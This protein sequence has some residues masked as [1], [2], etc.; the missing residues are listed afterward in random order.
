MLTK[1]RVQYPYLNFIFILLCSVFLLRLV[2]AAL[3]ASLSY[4]EDLADKSLESGPVVD[5]LKILLGDFSSATSPTEY[6]LIKLLIFV[7]IFFVVNV[8]MRKFPQF[9]D[10]RIVGAGISL[11]VSAIAIRFITSE[12]LINFIWLPYGV[13]GVFFASFLPFVLGYL[14]IEQ[15]DS[16]ISRKV[17]WTSYV[18]IFIGLAYLRWEDLYLPSDNPLG[19]VWYA[20][21]GMLYLII[22]FLSFLLIVFD[23]SIRG[24]MFR[25]S[26][27]NIGDRKKRVHAARISNEI[28][29]LRKELARTTD[30]GARNTLKNEIAALNRQ[31]DDLLHS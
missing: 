25:S 24:I 17:A 22:A 19:D 30:P 23:R 20:N 4:G 2:S 13:L 26:L 9:G 29:D 11:I 6:F 28:E 21:L 16:S 5:I 7:L 3:P 18:V 8:A 1:K 12:V 31:L 15:F 10:N 14:F 27:R